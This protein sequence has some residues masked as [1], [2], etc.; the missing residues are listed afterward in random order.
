MTVLKRQHYPHVGSTRSSDVVATPPA[1]YRGSASRALIGYG[2]ER[3]EFARRELLR[4]GV[5]TRSGF[6]VDGSPYPGPV[7]A[8][9]LRE[10]TFRIFGRVVREPVEVVWVVDDERRAGFGYGTRPGHPMRGEEAFLIDIDD[11]GAV[12]VTVRSFS[13]PAGRW[14]AITPLLRLA[15]RITTRRYLRAL[16]TSG[17]LGMP[18]RQGRG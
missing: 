16:A 12:H 17:I 10:L 2:E 1:G 15:Q 13:R 3:W 6:L 11:D 18:D 9:Q 8:G 4:W 7:V 5:K 14:R